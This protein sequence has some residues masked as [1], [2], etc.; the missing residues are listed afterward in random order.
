MKV[1]RR[2]GLAAA[3]EARGTLVVIDV[4]RAFTTA[5]HAFAR[6]ALQIELVATIEE[7]FA[8]RREDP[9]ALLVGE[10]DGRKVEGFDFGNSPPALFAADL[11]GRKLVLRSSAGTQGVVG[12]VNAR[13]ILLGS[14][15]VARATVAAVRALGDDVTLLAMGSPKGGPGDEDEVCAELLETRLA[16]GELDLEDVRRRVR[17]SRAGQKALDPTVDWIT[18]GDLECAQAIDRFDF[19]MRVERVGSRL[20]AR[21]S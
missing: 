8:R 11:A 7:A 18:P 14:L 19:A 17:D 13:T 4:L 16:G 21:R 12:G 9:R 10:T 15:V 6:G 3:V 2:S 5:A 1:E 20:V